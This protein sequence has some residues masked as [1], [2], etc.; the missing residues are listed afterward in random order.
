MPA[1]FGPVFA[2]LYDALDTLNAVD[3]ANLDAAAQTK[4]DDALDQL[5]E[6]LADA[7]SVALAQLDAQGENIA[8]VFKAATIKLDDD[9]ATLNNDLARVQTIA[10]SVAKLAAIIAPLLAA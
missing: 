6:L 7:H 10:D 3:P 4:R 1:N 5:Q 8:S 2:A 9:L